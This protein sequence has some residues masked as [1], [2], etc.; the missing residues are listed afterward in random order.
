MVTAIVVIN[1]LVS[2]AGLVLVWQLLA[3]RRSLVALTR[4]FESTERNL[5]QKLPQAREALLSGA[6][7]SRGVAQ[8]LARL[9]LWGQQLQQLLTLLSVLQTLRRRQS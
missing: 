9:K 7:S 6:E 1:S 4:T 2:I 5:A 3:W 8:R